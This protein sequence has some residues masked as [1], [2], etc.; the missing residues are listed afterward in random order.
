MK[1]L[2][3]LRIIN[4]IV[5]EIQRFKQFFRNDICKRTTETIKINKF[6]RKYFQSSILL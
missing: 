6:V 4:I 5:V 3:F 1:I 2:S